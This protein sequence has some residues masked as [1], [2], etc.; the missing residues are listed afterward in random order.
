MP[1]FTSCLEEVF[2]AT[3]LPV[4]GVQRKSGAQKE[5]DEG[6]VISRPSVPSVGALASYG[7][8]LALKVSLAALFYRNVSMS[9]RVD[10]IRRVS[11]DTQSGIRHRGEGARLLG[12]HDDVDVRASARREG[13]QF[14]CDLTPWADSAAI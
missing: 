10:L 12:D 13:A 3:A 9:Y 6:R 14:A 11:D 8:G 1:L 7:D 2:S 4:Y 5:E